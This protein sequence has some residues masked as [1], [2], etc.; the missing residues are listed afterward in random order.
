MPLPGSPRN[1][2]PQVLQE[3]VEPTPV[4]EEASV[5]QVLQEI[6]EPDVQIPLAPA[7]KEEVYDTVTTLP[8]NRVTRKVAKS[9]HRFKRSS[10]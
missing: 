9:N 10:E 8:K 6:V 3:I 4:V 5:P 7:V 2:K 1:K